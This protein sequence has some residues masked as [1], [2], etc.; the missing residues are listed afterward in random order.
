MS[1]LEKARVFLNSKNEPSQLWQGDQY[2]IIFDKCAAA[3]N[4]FWSADIQRFMNDICPDLKNKIDISERTLDQ[5][6]G[7][8]SLEEFRKELSKFY[9]LHQAVKKMYMERKKHH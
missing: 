2:K 3:I 6:W 7:L 1:Y 4:E 8:K 9:Q 5:L